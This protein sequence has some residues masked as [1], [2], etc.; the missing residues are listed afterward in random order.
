MSYY[1][2]KKELVNCINLFK[3]NKKL[4]AELQNKEKTKKMKI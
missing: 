2:E 4:N 1:I 3:L